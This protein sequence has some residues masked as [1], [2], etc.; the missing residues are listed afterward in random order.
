MAKKTPGSGL[1]VNRW[2]Q[3]GRDILFVN[4]ESGEKVGKFDLQSKQIYVEK[5]M[6]HRRRD[7]ELALNEWRRGTS[8]RHPAPVYRN[9]QRGRPRDLAEQRAGDSLVKVAHERRIQNRGLRV[10]ARVL[11][12]KTGEESWLKGAAGER[13]VGRRLDKLTAKGWHVLHGVQ[14]P[15]GGDVDHLVIGPSGVHTINTKFHDGAV[16]KVRG[17]KVHVG[18]WKK[19]YPAAARREATRVA[20]VLHAQGIRVNVSPMIVS[21]GHS[22]L[23]GWRWR[24]PGGV[25]IIP[26]SAIRRRFR[27]LG[28]GR[29]VLDPLAVA[30]VFAVARRS[31]SWERA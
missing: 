16:L 30:D 28:R 5:H 8:R 26:A 1:Y 15:G 11:G 4:D 2:Q 19:D 18:R 24:R 9:D 12:M 7:F 17:D 3:H 25:S 6:K 13:Q 29:P 21:Y 22:K 23:S 10:L 31:E 20:E 27:A 14:L